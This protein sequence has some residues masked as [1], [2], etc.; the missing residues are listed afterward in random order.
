LRWHPLTIEWFGKLTRNEVPSLRS[1]DNRE[2]FPVP[3]MAFAMIGVDVCKTTGIS[4]WTK[5]PGN[6]SRSASNAPSSETHAVM[7]AGKW[8]V[9][10]P[11]VIN[12]TIG[13]PALAAP[14]AQGPSEPADAQ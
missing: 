9:P 6:A 1:A 8:I 14:E 7:F 12:G 10:E 4:P 3:K 2:I 13:S 5:L 11:S